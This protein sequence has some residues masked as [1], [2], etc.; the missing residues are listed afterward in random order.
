MESTGDIVGPTVGTAKRERQKANKAMREQELARKR[1]KSRTIRIGLMVAAAIV[2]VFV[3]VI[4]AGRFIDDEDTTNSSAPAV[5]A[6]A[7]SAA[8][9]VS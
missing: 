2:A 4:I 3:L 9:D 8:P 7:V 6:V 5:P 1:T